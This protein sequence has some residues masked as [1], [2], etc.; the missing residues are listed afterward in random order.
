MRHNIATSA[1]SRRK[2]T[3]SSELKAKVDKYR[4]FA[5]EEFGREIQVWS[6]AYVYHGDT[7]AD[8][9]ALWHHAVQEFGRLARRHQ[10]ARGHG[11]DLATGAAAGSRLPQQHFIAGWAGYPL[12]GGKEQIVDG[13]AVLK[14]AGFDGILLTWPRWLEGMMRFRD[15]VMPLL[16]QAGLR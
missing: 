15:E 12:V 1:S 14:R 6:N 13:L 5:R 3:S 9:K 10:H 11:R 2:A 4:N 16:A 8:G 7:E